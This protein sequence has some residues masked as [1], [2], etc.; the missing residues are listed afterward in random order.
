[1]QRRRFGLLAAKVV[2]LGVACS[3]LPTPHENFK[4]II[5]GRVGHNINVDRPSNKVVSVTTLANG[6]KELGIQFLRTCRYF[7][8]VDADGTILAWRFEGKDSD[9]VIPP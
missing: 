5:G 6:H 3:T 9:C 7:Y 4:L 1:M 8:E 2:L